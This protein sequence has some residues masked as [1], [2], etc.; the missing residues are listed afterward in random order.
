MIEV[1]EG[2][3]KQLNY[4]HWLR[5]LQQMLNVDDKERGFLEIRRTR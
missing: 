5:M 1:A 3:A 4:Q 2:V